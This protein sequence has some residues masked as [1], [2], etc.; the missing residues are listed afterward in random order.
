MDTEMLSEDELD[1]RLRQGNPVNRAALDDEEV[2]AALARVLRTIEAGARREERSRPASRPVHR[3]RWATLG[4]A[5]AVAAVAS[6]VGVKTLTGGAGGPSLP[7][8]VSPAAAA[9]LDKVAHAAAVQVAAGAGQFEYLAE[10]IET[11]ASTSV[12]G[13]PINYTYDQTIQNWDE[14]TFGAQG[15]R[16]RT[17]S[18]GIAFASA[19]DQ[20][21][22][23]ANKSAF[24]ATFSAQFAA[25]DPTAT[26]LIA[27]D[28]YKYHPAQAPPAPA[29]M[30]PA[31]AAIYREVMALTVRPDSPRALLADLRL[32]FSPQ[33]DDLWGALVTILRSSTSPQLRATAYQALSYVPGT[34]VLGNQKDQLGRAGIA[35]HFPEYAGGPADTLIVSPATGYI[36]ELDVAMKVPGGTTL[37]REIDLQHSV[38]D[39]VTALP[40]GGD[41]PITAA[42]RNVDLRTGTVTPQTTTSGSQTTTSTPQATTSGSQTTSSTAQTSTTASQTTTSASQSS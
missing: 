4:V 38:V 36:L 26:G 35:I 6:L 14:P 33:A 13:A 28:L 2:G 25:P 20:A 10:K 17:T 30:S 24:D 32:A 40:D 29:G 3:R 31:D 1:L 12:G 9:Q 22:Y 15:G 19:Q 37:S 7:L 27:D 18:Q 23:L 21:N 8:A 11:A 41:Q 16:Q 39:S 5:T 34:T 42:T